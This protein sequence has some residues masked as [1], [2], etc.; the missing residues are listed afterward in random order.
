MPKHPI[1]KRISEW[2]V[3]A[4][5]AFFSILV[6]G[7]LFVAVFKKEWVKAAI[8]YVEVAV[9]GL[10]NWNFFIAFVSSVIESFP[11]IGVL[12]P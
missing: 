1:L 8:A 4:L 10:G 11:V 7:L 3:S 12:V 5:N 2:L 6:F 9:N